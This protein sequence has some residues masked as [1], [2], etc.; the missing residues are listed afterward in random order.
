[1]T[2]RD[3]RRVSAVE[4]LVRLLL[5]AYP[6]R[7]RAR[8]EREVLASVREDLES[9]ARH[10]AA[11]LA[12]ASVREVTQTLAGVVP[13]HRLDRAAM[14]RRRGPERVMEELRSL[15]AE[16]RHAVRSLARTPAFTLVALVVVSLGIGASTAVFSVV[17]AVVLRALPFDASD[18]LAAVLETDPARPATFGSGNTTTQNFLDWR[19][20]LTVFESLEAV[21]S[22]RFDTEDE[23]GQ[24]ADVRGAR[25]TAGFFDLLRV[26]PALGRT[27]VPGDEREAHPVAVVSWG[28]WQQRFG[29]APDVIGRTITLG[30]TPREIVGVLPR[31]FSYPVAS[32]SP[33]QVFVPLVFE[34]TDRVRGGN[35]NYNYLA[36]GRLKPGVSMAAASDAVFAVATALDQE[37]PKWYQ[38]RRA[39]AIPLRDHIVGRVR[40]WMLMLLGAVAF[41]LL[42]ACANVAN[43]MLAR[44]TARGRELGIRAALGAGRARLARAL[45]VESLILSTAGTVLGVGVGW[46]G[47]RAIRAWLPEGLPRLEAIAV[48]W[49]V[50]AVAAAAAVVTGVLFGLLPA[51][52]SSRPN[53]GQALRD[54]GRSGAAGVARGRARAALVVAEVAMATVLLVGAGLFVASFVKLLRVDPGFDYAGVLTP[55][56]VGVPFDRSDFAGSVARGRALSLAV[57]DAVAAVPGVTEVA[58]VNGGLP[59]TGNWS[60]TLVAMPGRGQLKGEDNDLDLREVTPGYLPL[61]RLPLR[62]GRLLADT[63]RE[64]TPQ[65]VVINE[66]AARKYWPDEPALGRR[67]TID[68]VERTVVGIVGDIRHLGPEVPPRQEAYVPLRQSNV[69]G[70]DLVVRA[71]GDPLAVLP[72][73]RAA[74]WRV[75]PDQRLRPEAL[76]FDAYFDKLVAQRRFNMALL[77]LFGGLGL[78]IAVVGIYGVMAYVVSQRTAEFGVRMALGATR[79]RLVSLVLRQAGML[80]GLGLIMGSVVAWWFGGAVSGFLYDLEASD[81]RV[82]AAALFVLA[83]AGLAASVVP[84]RRAARV[85]PLV[86]LRGD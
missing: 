21:S 44:A 10:G 18:R 67:I 69:I 76:T 79:G 25:V 7:F 60:R 46:A 64:G 12:A 51:L 2:L 77:S 61:L 43:L 55:G 30:G 49:R 11:A 32:P 31:D 22:R 78:V 13:Q 39:R 68:D 9:A 41:V 86:A 84:A 4:R 1:M 48:D 36:I 56:E 29:G 28:F 38:G 20:R 82:F 19:A 17:D 81:V 53:L 42:I 62:A 24:P 50:L 5:R 23:L 80:V 33:F 73:V 54:G 3:R 47:V 14:P 37:Y 65:V 8:F 6:A 45:L 63:D 66:A 16:A 34:E 59:F 40:T 72:A 71:D 58:G 26:P 52:Q 35:R 15:G 70:V 27:F 57:V 83:V 85:D 75:A 74:I